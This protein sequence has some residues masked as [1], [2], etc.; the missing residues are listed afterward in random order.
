MGEELNPFTEEEIKLMNEEF[1]KSRDYFKKH[2]DEARRASNKKA[3][4]DNRSFIDFIKKEESP[5][6]NV[7]SF[8]VELYYN[9]NEDVLIMGV[10]KDYQP[11]VSVK[12]DKN[13]Y[14]D[15]DENRT[16]VAL[17]ILNASKTFNV[18]KD[19]FLEKN[20]L[21]FSMDIHV[22]FKSITVNAFFR[23]NAR[24]KTQEKS[25]SPNISNTLRLPTI[26]S[27]ADLATV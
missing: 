14:L 17:R 13:I 4:T 25:I 15:F 22:N 26:N 6:D 27:V 9:R 23:L 10:E 12:L 1:R 19:S 8:T 16:P 11:D 20:F 24:N 2:P 21:G 5:I 3:E 18:V 7:N